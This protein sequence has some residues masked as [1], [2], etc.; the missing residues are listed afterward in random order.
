MPEVPIALSIGGIFMTSIPK[1][2]PAE[3]TPLKIPSED[4]DAERV[5]PTC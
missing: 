3:N 4:G 2:P 5:F 1:I